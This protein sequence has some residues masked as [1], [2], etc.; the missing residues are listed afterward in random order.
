[1][2]SREDD[3]CLTRVGP[4]THKA[5]ILESADPWQARRLLLAA[6]RTVH[7]GGTPHGVAPTSCGLRADEGVRPRDADWRT[8]LTPDEARPAIVQTV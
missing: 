7:E 3:E 8:A 6:A 5:I 2:L 4:G 1:M